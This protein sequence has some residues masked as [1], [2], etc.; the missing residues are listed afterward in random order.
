M[1]QAFVLDRRIAGLVRK[2]L[3]EAAAK[4]AKELQTWKRPQREIKRLFERDYADQLRATFGPGEIRSLVRLAAAI[5]PNFNRSP[6]G[7]PSMELFAEV[8]G[9]LRLVFS[10]APYRKRGGFAV[11]G[12]YVKSLAT[13]GKPL[14]LC[15][16]RAS[17]VGRRYCVLP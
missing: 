7:P 10:S 17:P 1:T 9:N 8:S 12:F 4:S 6:M 3:S 13:V 11:R 14:Y 5:W 16:Q 15:Q 2:I